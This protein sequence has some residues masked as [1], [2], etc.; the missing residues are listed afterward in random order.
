MAQYHMAFTTLV[1]VDAL[2]T[3]LSDPQWIIFD[4]RF[5]LADPQAGL[6]AYQASHIPGARYADLDRDLSRGKT[7]TTGRHPLP[8]P[9]VFADKLG[10]WG[11]DAGKQ[12]VAYD[13]NT[14]A[15]AARLWWLLRW[16][17]H[18]AVAVLD[19]G[20]AAWQQQGGP[21]ET[22][23]PRPTATRFVAKPNDRMWV[24]TRYIEEQLQ[25][26]EDLLVDA[27]APE[28]F[29]GEQEPLDPVAGH[30]P[31]AVNRPLERNLDANGKFLPASTLRAAFV[32]LSNTKPPDKVIHSCGSGV[33]A[34]HNLLA[35][36]IAGLSGSRL[37]PG[38]WSEWIRD[39]R[40]P[41]AT[42]S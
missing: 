37:Y 14:N 38:S 41:V 40:H 5:R 32:D 17:G 10:Q 31:G 11:V 2:K 22:T 24:R 3:H 20:F 1:T 16:L 42:G 26:P 27:R 6:R 23:L 12:V 39:P 4:C 34:C 19:G 30:I 33:S 9:P 21:L 13:D 7:V 36:E 15:I 35:M 8:K 25:Q 18:Y 28:R 29:R